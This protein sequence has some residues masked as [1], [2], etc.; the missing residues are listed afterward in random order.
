MVEVIGIANFRVRKRFAE[1]IGGL[2]PRLKRYG[3]E[4]HLRAARAR[5]SILP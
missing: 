1:I 5:S 3:G 4:L 2:N